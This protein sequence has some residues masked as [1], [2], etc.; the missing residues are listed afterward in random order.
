MNRLFKSSSDIF[1]T[2]LTLFGLITRK[3]LGKYYNLY[4]FLFFPWRNSPQ[5]ASAS[6]LSRLHDHTQTHHT[7]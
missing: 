3:A 4:I 1:H 6:S 5:W 7:L 2:N